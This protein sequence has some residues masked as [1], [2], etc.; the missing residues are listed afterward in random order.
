MGWSIGYDHNWD[1]DIGY[2]VPAYCDHPGCGAEIDR[3]LSYVCGGQPYGGDRGCGLYFC[4]KHLFPYF[5]LPQLCERCGPRKKTPFDPTPDHPV[6]IQ[7]KLTDESWQEWR[8]ENPD[9]VLELQEKA[10]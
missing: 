7:H 8:D 9:K 2:G 1:R 3:G 10:A 5:R 6:W 4:G